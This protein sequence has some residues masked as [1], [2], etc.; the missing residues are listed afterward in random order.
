MIEGDGSINPSNAP[1]Q[2]NGDTYTLADDINMTS[3]TECIEVWAN[4]IVLDGANH[5][6]TGLNTYYYSPPTFLHFGIYLLGASNVTVKDFNIHMF[7]TGIC[8]EHSDNDTIFNNSITINYEGIDLS[9]SSYNNITSNEI[10]APPIMFDPNEDGIVLTNSSY[11]SIT[12]NRLSRI[13]ISDT[14]QPPFSVNNLIIHNDIYHAVMNSPA[15]EIWD[16]GY[17]S[18]GNLWE[19]Y[20]GYDLFS[21]PY[22][23]ETGSDGIGDTPYIINASNIDHYPWMMM[24]TASPVLP[25]AE[26]DA[27]QSF[28]TLKV[29]DA[30]TFNA[31]SSIV[32]WN[33]TSVE[34]ITKYIWDFGDGNIT[35]T[36]QRALIHVF[37]SA[38]YK[39]FSVQLTV[40][41]AEN[42]N[43]S[44]N[45]WIQVIMP[46][47][48]SI[49]T[50]S[51]SSLLGF[52]VGINGTLCDAF[53]K[54]LNNETVLLYYTFSGASS[55]FPITSYVTDNLGR[56]S[57]QWIPTATGSFTVKAEWSGN[58]TGKYFS[59]TY[60]GANSTVS[61]CTI[62]YENQYIFTVESNSTISNLTFNSTDNTLDFTA[63]GANGTM[64]YTK[65]TI[66]KSLVPDKPN[67]KVIVDGKEE[68]YTIFGLDNSWVLTFAYSH[69]VHQVQIELGQ[70]STIEPLLLVILL[71]A[72][73]VIVALLAI[74][75]YNRKHRSS[76]KS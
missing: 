2:R 9:K 73:I 35:S 72:I 23:N 38:P 66:P 11:N 57:A 29:G 19:L 21:G 75:V 5:T 43:S 62:P 61:V 41:D 17:P 39:G 60:L 26:I 14:S 70:P 44:R 7:Y 27:P 52:A 40:V 15:H 34:P 58:Y 71:I 45:T 25:K 31:T 64:G 53:G 69:S 48:I 18:G 56:Y 68:H 4:N 32:G 24:R 51:S 76:E 1:I 54:G 65:V 20:E 13:L 47:S 50:T 74:I 8:L 3:A 55:W 28:T 33:G 59:G 30:V 42:K 63:S 49:S 6:I 10:I 46:N 16:A 36:T 67:L 12:E 22:Q 37:K